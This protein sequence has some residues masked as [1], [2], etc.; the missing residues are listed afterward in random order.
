MGVVAY[1]FLIDGRRWEEEDMSRLSLARARCSLSYSSSDIS[2]LES[3]DPESDSD[4]DASPLGNAPGMLYAR[5]DVCRDD[6]W[7]L[8]GCGVEEGV[9]FNGVAARA[10]YARCNLA[11]VLNFGD[12]GDV[13][14]GEGWT[15]YA[16]C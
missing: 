11:E 5:A 14:I 8:S 1:C 4:D 13:L 12:V 10:E 16:C 6:V 15:G 2:E 3:S 9:A 7:R